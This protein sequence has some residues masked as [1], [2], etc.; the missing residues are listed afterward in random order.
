MLP[1]LSQLH[2]T[3][4]QLTPH[5]PQ[6]PLQLLLVLFLLLILMVPQQHLLCLRKLQLT[7]MILLLLHLCLT[8]MLLRQLP[9]PSMAT[10]CPHLH[11]LLPVMGPLHL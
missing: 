4:G 9:L 3:M 7:P 1:L 10:Q 2:L 8:A 11:L 6:H 5:P